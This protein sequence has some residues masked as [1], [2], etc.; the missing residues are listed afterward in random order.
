MAGRLGLG[1]MSVIPDGWFWT[2][3]LQFTREEISGTVRNWRKAS[4]VGSFKT[5]VNGDVKKMGEGGNALHIPHLRANL[6]TVGTFAEGYDNKGTNVLF[7]AK[8][9]KVIDDRKGSRF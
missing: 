1:S 7:S 4:R 6:L 2:V 5:T 8:G 9:A 3:D